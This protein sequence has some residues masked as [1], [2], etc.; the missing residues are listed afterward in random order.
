MSNWPRRI[1]WDEFAGR[2]SRP[3]GVD[4][5]AQIHS[6]GILP[7]NLT[8]VNENGRLRLP[9]ITVELSVDRTETWVV[10][11][12]K[13][14]ELLAHEQGHYDITGLVGR[15]LAADLAALRGGS[16]RELQR[17]VTRLM[18]HHRGEAGRLTRLYDQ[19]TNHSRNRDEQSRWEGRIGEAIRQGTR[20]T[21][22]AP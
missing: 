7:S 1:S 18:E 4:E 22:S 5:D 3:L 11:S 20:F 8:P 17:K 16:G 10:T 21:R 9:A 15:D 14:A 13:T 12:R 6:E 19:E 2:D